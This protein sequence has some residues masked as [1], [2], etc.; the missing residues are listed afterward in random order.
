MEN[1]IRGNTNRFATFFLYLTDVESGGYTY[2]PRAGQLP[3]PP[4]LSQFVGGG[5]V[6]CF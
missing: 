4:V 1:T 6:M 5:F 3:D 2:F